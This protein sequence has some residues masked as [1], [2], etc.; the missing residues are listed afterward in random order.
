[1]NKNIQ[2]LSEEYL[3]KFNAD[4]ILMSPPCQPFTRNGLCN[5]TNDPRTASFI[6][7]LNLLPKLNVENLLIENVRGFETSNMRNML[8]ETLQINNY[9]FQE[10]ILNPTQIG[11]P[12]SRLRY[13]CLAK[14]HLGKF[15]FETTNSIV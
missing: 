6:H 9:L 1:M 8:I 12:N 4:T 2:G 7:L 3:K 13:Y 10:F 14:K 11:I 15:K 5:D